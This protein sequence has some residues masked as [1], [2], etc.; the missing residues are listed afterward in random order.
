MIEKIYTMKTRK[1]RQHKWDVRFLEL[2]KFIS[3]WSQDPST[4]VGAVVVDANRVVRGMGY[5][6]FPRGVNDTPERYN[7]RE[8]KYQFVVHAEVNCCI[9]S[10]GD[11][12]GGT[13]YVYPTLMAPPVCPECCKMVIQYGISRL[14]C[15]AG[16]T[17][18]RWQDMAHISETMLKEAGVVVDTI[19]L[20]ELHE[21]SKG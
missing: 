14:V 3:T 20:E 1:E 18:D 8:V 6:G 21:D 13:M 10:I 19:E 5:N 12:K 15:Y 17:S 16:P 2:A 4:K 7:E 9:N 11:I